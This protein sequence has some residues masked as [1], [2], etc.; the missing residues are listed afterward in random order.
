MNP[1]QKSDPVITSN[2]KFASFR[3]KSVVPAVT[4]NVSPDSVRT[5]SI[6][7]QFTTPLDNGRPALVVGLFLER[8]QQLIECLDLI[9]EE[10]QPFGYC[11]FENLLPNTEYDIL[12]EVVYEN[13][14]MSDRLKVTTSPPA[15]FLIE[16]L[17]L[18][19]SVV[20]DWSNAWPANIQKLLKS[21][22]V[23]F[24]RGLFPDITQDYNGLEEPTFRKDGL[25]SLETY[26]LEISGVFATG[27]T[28]PLVVRNR[29]ALPP[30][31]VE[32]SRVGS[33]RMTL[34]WPFQQ[35]EPDD[36]QVDLTLSVLVRKFFFK[37]NNL[38]S[39][40]DH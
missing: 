14:E 19:T 9:W 22:E 34:S 35:L 29:T 24:T 38:S 1:K 6:Q 28:D 5:T 4:L 37:T 40:N 36:Y 39:K 16:E 13:G 12:L 18:S 2:Q 25:S 10:N 3:T 11:E 20:I 27:K 33:T 7:A 31:Q 32:L 17:A 30:P 23:K 8:N 26:V 21:Y 15:P